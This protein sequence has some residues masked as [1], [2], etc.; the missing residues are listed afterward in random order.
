MR[1][2][3]LVERDTLRTSLG[4]F[5]NYFLIF[6]KPAEGVAPS[7]SRPRPS[8]HLRPFCLLSPASP[9]SPCGSGSVNGCTSQKELSAQACILRSFLAFSLFTSPHDSQCSATSF[10]LNLPTCLFSCQDS[11]FAQTVSPMNS[12]RQTP[13][14]LPSLLPFGSA[15]FSVHSGYT[16]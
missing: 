8:P 16:T 15:L 11:I 3:K 7:A 5:F 1:F 2:C 13:H 12:V 9:C 10:V 14:Y 6:H 4:L